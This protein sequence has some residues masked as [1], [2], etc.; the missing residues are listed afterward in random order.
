MPASGNLARRIRLSP[1]PRRPWSLRGASTALVFACISASFTASAQGFVPGDVNSDGAF[2]VRDF[3]VLQR[4]VGALPPGISQLCLVRGDINNDGSLDASDVVSLRR[5]LAHLDSA[6]AQLCPAPDDDHDGFSTADGDCDD[7]NALVNRGAF[8]IAANGLDDDC[9]GTGDNPAPGCDAGIPSNAS[10]GLEY[11]RAMDLC[12]TTL[13]SPPSNLRTWGVISAAFTLPSG[14]GSPVAVARSVRSSFGSGNLPRSGS[15]MAVMSTGN[16]AAVGQT[17]PPHV[18]FQGGADLGSSSAFP[19]DWLAANGGS[20]PNAPGCPEVSGSVARDAI[21]LTLRIRVPTNARSFRLS[22]S[23]LSAEYPEWVCSEFNDFFVV[24]LDST[25][26]GSPANPVDK[27]LAVLANALGAYPVGV[28]LAFGNTGLFTQCLNGPTGC[29][30]PS[31]PGVQATCTGTSGL[32]GTS[33]D[34]VNPA[35]KFA[36]SPGFCGTSNLAGGGTGWLVIQGNVEPG[37]VID[38][39]L[40]LWDSSDGWYDAVVLLDDFEW[41]ATSTQPGASAN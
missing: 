5:V 18:A 2:D 14:S 19:A 28:N 21:M 13:E 39:R 32:S 7:S 8:E 11:A 41:S 31:V 23:F 20:L 40:A 27:N 24:L 29:A 38:L 3:A 26:A 4:A 35:P 36:S 10:T 22:G 16:A 17:N 15:A 33:M 37:E 34:T 30:E 9:D 25:F 12:S 6:V 1:E